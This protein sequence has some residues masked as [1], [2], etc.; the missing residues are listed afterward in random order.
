MSD[1]V[2][3]LYVGDR[4]RWFGL[5]GLERTGTVEEGSHREPFGTVLVRPDDGLRAGW[6]D[7]YKL[8]RA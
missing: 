4:V 8:A 5:D 1:D 6:I 7:Q 3:D 2:G